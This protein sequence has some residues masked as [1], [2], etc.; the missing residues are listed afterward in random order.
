M[1]RETLVVKGLKTIDK[2]KNASHNQHHEAHDD[3][4]QIDKD[5]ILSPLSLFC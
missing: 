2:T 5:A 1:E 3:V 4:Q